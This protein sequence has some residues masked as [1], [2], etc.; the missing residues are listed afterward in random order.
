MVFGNYNK[1]LER[2]KN[3]PY[4]YFAHAGWTKGIL[5]GIKH[6]IFLEDKITI[7]EEK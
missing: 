2:L 1:E 3:P 6:F 7:K 5:E 4:I